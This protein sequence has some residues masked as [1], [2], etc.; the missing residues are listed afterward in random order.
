[1]PHHHHYN[2][3]HQYYRHQHHHQYHYYYNYYYSYYVFIVVMNNKVT[4]TLTTANAAVY[5]ELGQYPLRLIILLQ[6]YNF[7][8]KITKIQTS[9]KEEYHTLTHIELHVHVP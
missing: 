7:Y 6:T 9:L 1:M 2:K 5:G 8:E 3:H 4:I